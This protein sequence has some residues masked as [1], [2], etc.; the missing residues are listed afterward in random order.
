MN[1]PRTAG[2]PQA[3]VAAALAGDDSVAPP[4][5]RYWDRASGNLRSIAERAPSVT[6]DLLATVLADALE[7]PDPAAAINNLER[8]TTALD[9]SADTRLPPLLTDP[10][11][12]MVL[13]A[14]FGTSQYLSD[15]LIHL[16]VLT[17]WLLD[18][19]RLHAQRTPADFRAEAELI[20]GSTESRDA[21]KAALCRMKRRALLRI[22]CRDILRLATT[23]QVTR[24]ISD[25]AE[26]VVHAAATITFNEMVARFGRPIPEA[27][28]REAPE[29]FRDVPDTVLAAGM[30][31]IGMGK[32]G[33]R[34]LNF[35]SDID[36]IFIYDAEG[37][38]TGCLPDGRR[39]APQTNHVFFTRMGE[40]MVKFLS[41]RGPD[42]NL[43]RVDMRLRPEGK[44]GPL[45]RS[46]ES[47]LRYLEEQ[48]RDWERL[49]YLKARVLS[50]SAQLAERIYRFTQEFVFAEAQPERI[51]HE[52]QN[53]KIMIDREVMQGELYHREVKRGFGGIREIEF[54]IA[55][56]QIVYGRQHRALRVRNIFVAVERLR[57]VNLIPPD[58]ADFY[59]EAYDFLR[60]VE[61]RL[62][63]AEEHQ[64]HTLPS[65]PHRIEVL[66]RQCGLPDAASFTAEYK[67]ITTGVHERFTRFFEQDI[68]EMGRDE[69]D[70]LLI[71]DRDA[72]P[73]D[74]RAALARRG[75]TQSNALSLIH[76][77]A[78]GT[79]DVFIT[80][81][82]QRSF[83]QMLPSLLR[84]TA[85][86]PAPQRVLPHMHSFVLSI[87][88]I[89]YYYELIAQ[90]P[91]ILKLLVT[92]FGTSDYFSEAFIAHPQF[93]DALLTSQV[94]QERTEFNAQLERVDAVV[95]ISRKLDRQQVLLRRAAKFEML[96]VALRYM[97]NLRSLAEVFR[98]LTQTADVLLAAA[99]PLAAARAA[100]RF[101]AI[102]GR[103]D[104]AIAPDAI[105]R[106]AKDVFAVIALGKYGGCELNFFGDLDVVF[107]YDDTRANREDTEYFSILSDSLSSVVSEQMEEGR[108]FALDARLR[109][110]GKNAPL[111]ASLSQYRDY[112]RTE[113]QVWEH[114]S[115]LRAR[116]VYG[117]REIVQELHAA[118]RETYSNLD[119]RQLRSEVVQMRRRLEESVAADAAQSVEFKRSP[120]GFTDVEFVLQHLALSGSLDAQSAPSSYL[121]LLDMPSLL[122]GL[123]PEIISKLRYGYATL[124]R[125]DAAERLITGT[126][127][128]ALPT[129]PEHIRA[130]ERLVGIGEGQATQVVRECMQLI[131]EAYEQVL[132]MASS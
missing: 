41:E 130:I 102:G 16:P 108:V 112:L 123:S 126:G 12:L 37:Y 120:G 54:V 105:L 98:E 65:E 19:A 53:L 46:L 57:E 132:G 117:R 96:L 99:M 3:A 35:A 94:L 106:Q 44:Y 61:H 92:L 91:E 87:R 56:M 70:A 6:P 127:Q 90:H 68:A 25:M 129:N 5:F 36:L 40:A 51:V 115:F 28:G 64:T 29:D 50:G 76:S 124:R 31:V 63:M 20:A 80:A 82:G 23:E 84:M 27:A 110:H 77:L 93:F 42:G 67:R 83:E 73:E 81:E 75:I 100:E 39:I 118:S 26:A 104:D 8:Y 114:Q 97:L 79:S 88:G 34:E 116:H 14:L 66:A 10:E 86:A 33:G 7:S 52:I 109:P 13:V 59:F 78:Y 38:T 103:E 24:E 30:C 4:G 111:A 17:Q 2:T 107:V 43:F 45:A 60:R 21:K 122:K 131:R 119:P 72:P 18:P 11:S 55:A 15:V 71:L 95:R 49:A 47:F 128:S 58:E 62:Q 89:T 1:A 69:R 9:D 32:L 101:A 48:A 22:G 121:E 85:A 74:A 125:I 113:A